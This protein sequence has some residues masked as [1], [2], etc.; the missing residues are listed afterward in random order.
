MVTHHTKTLIQKN[1]AWVNKSGASFSRPGGAW[2]SRWWLHY[3]SCKLTEFLFQTLHF[4]LYILNFTPGGFRC[5][6]WWLHC[7]S[8]KLAALPQILAFL[9][10]YTQCYY[11]LLWV[12]FLHFKLY[13]LHPVLLLV[14]LPCKSAECTLY[15]FHSHLYYPLTNLQSGGFEISSIKL[16]HSSFDTTYI[17]FIRPVNTTDIVWR[18]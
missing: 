12:L 10:V 13:G 15:S 1:V 5:S 6:P 11:A 9:R 8:C 14:D 4:K 7:L 17:I 3:L 18:G 2:W 16:A